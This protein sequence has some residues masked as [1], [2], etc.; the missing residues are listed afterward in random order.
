MSCICQTTTMMTTK[1]KEYIVSLLPSKYQSSSYHH[2]IMINDHPAQHPC[3]IYTWDV[4]DTIL[5]INAKQCSTTS[6]NNE[7]NINGTSTKRLCGVCAM[8]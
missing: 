4:R 7:T 3:T 5:C 8:R 1:S 6:Y 2:D